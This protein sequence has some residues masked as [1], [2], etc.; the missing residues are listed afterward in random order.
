MVA[1]TALT[2]P[3]R[4]WRKILSDQLAYCRQSTISIGYLFPGI[5]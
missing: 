2:P 4:I 1:W 3:S 5:S